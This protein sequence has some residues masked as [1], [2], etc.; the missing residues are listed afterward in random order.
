MN[1]NNSQTFSLKYVLLMVTL[2]VSSIGIAQNTVQLSDF[3]FLDNTDWIGKLMYINYSDGREVVIDADL[4][5]RIEKKKLIF[6]SKYPKEPKA[7]DK[8]IIK[9]SDDGT[10]FGKETV[11]VFKNDPSNGRLMMITTSEGKDNNQ[12]AMFIKTYDFNGDKAIITKEVQY[13]GAGERF[14]RNKYSYTKL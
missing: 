4:S 10:Q 1:K 13:A 8:S 3:N 6:E 14:I 9:I 2:L 12:M 7:N 11:T 5:I